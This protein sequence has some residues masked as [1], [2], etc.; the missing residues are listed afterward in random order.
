MNAEKNIKRERE[1]ATKLRS[2]ESIMKTEKMTAVAEKY[3]SSVDASAARAAEDD[4]M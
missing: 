1:Q 3:G 2:Y 4:F